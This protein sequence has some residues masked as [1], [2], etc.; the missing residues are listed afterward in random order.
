MHLLAMISD[1]YAVSSQVFVQVKCA[2][3]FAFSA[4]QLLLLFRPP[5]NNTIN[6][7]VFL[8]SFACS[9]VQLASCLWN[10]LVETLM[11]FAQILIGDV[12]QPL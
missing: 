7:L 8:S 1:I 4:M 10:M 11:S 9:L 12:V 2:R 5:A 3:T 6:D